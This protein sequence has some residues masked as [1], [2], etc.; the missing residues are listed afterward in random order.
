VGILRNKRMFQYRKRK[1]E[2][3]EMG[4]SVHRRRHMTQNLQLTENKKTSMS[5]MSLLTH[6]MMA[7]QIS[8]KRSCIHI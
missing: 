2:E 7:M 1:E 3:E 4:E 5:E 6:K 8:R